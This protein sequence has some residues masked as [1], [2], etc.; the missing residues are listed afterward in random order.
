MDE[1]YDQWRKELIEQGLLAPDEEIDNI[2]LSK[3]WQ[4]YQVKKMKAA[5]SGSFRDLFPG[6]KERP[7]RREAVTPP[8]MFEGIESPFDFT[9]HD[10]PEKEIDPRSG[11]KQALE[12]LLTKASGASYCMIVV[13]RAWVN[14]RYKKK[15][16]NLHLQVAGNKYI[17]PMKLEESDIEHLEKMGILPEPMSVEIWARD[18]DDEPRDLDGIIET[19]IEIFKDVYHVDAEDDAYVELDL[20]KGEDESVLEDIAKYFNRRSGKQFKWQWDNNI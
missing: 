20:G 7:E 17:T 15:K 19:V 4:D 9:T 6:D 2:E 5:M 14:F 11:I 16:N 10:E 3:R 8:T 13:N 1:I 12:A 18:F